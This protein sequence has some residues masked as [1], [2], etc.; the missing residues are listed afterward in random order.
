MA[1]DLTQETLIAGWRSIRRYQGTCQL[2]T[3]LC[4]ILLYRHKSAVRRRS[5]RNLI[6]PFLPGEQTTPEVE[7]RIPSPDQAAELSE[8]AGRILETLDR[9]PR[10]QRE[11]IFLRFYADESLEGI[12]AALDCSLGT[13][14]SRLFHALANLRKMRYFQEDRR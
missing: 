5:W 4:S 3:W 10:R 6:A 12:A 9:L 7:E 8:R 13:V 1:Q 2:S 14:K 11:V